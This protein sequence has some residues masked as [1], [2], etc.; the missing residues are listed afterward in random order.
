[1]FKHTYIDTI[2][3]PHEGDSITF[4][5]TSRQRGTSPEVAK[6]IVQQGLKLPTSGEIISLLYNAFENKELESA[7]AFLD[8]FEWYR[9][10]WEYTSHIF[11]G[12]KTHKELG[13]G[14]ILEDR[15]NIKKG[16]IITET[17]NVDDYGE[18]NPHIESLVNRLYQDDPSVRF[19]PFEKG[20][21]GLPF[22]KS[23]YLI[24][25]YGVEG[26]EKFEKLTSKYFKNITVDF[27]S[28]EHSIKKLN[29]GEVIKK[30]P[31]LYNDDGK[32]YAEDSSVLGKLQ[33]IGL[34]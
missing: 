29:E 23:K 1:M 34:K 22:P 32:F 14:L 4:D 19:L 13:P 5:M 26:A 2:T 18:F 12:E 24:A 15:P 30:I 3:V 28:H 33:S 11:L 10:L 9:G 31:A 7:R 16:N 27:L 6:N 20:F 21:N 8:D 25:R 17:D